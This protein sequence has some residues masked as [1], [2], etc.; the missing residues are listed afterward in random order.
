MAV[1]NLESFVLR[2][3]R[4]KGEV[5]DRHKTRTRAAA[6]YGLQNL[7][8]GT[9]VDKGRARGNWQVTEG[10]P[11]EGF[12]PER[13]DASGSLGNADTFGE[14]TQKVLETSGSD[15]IWIHNGVPYIQVLEGM[16][17]MLAGAV[18]ALRTW[19]RSKDP[20]GGAV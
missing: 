7:V 8:F 20:A 9:R 16:D 3:R 19:L 12:D 15:I 18:E 13:Y 1:T 2:V 14:E 5:R 10:S 6:L 11:A 17:H 4:S